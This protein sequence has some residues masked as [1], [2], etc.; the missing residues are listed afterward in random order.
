MVKKGTL[1]NSM[2]KI[3][4]IFLLLI[5]LTGCGNNPSND[6]V[7]SVSE[8][9]PITEKI[10][11]VGEIYGEC[12]ILFD[13]IDYSKLPQERL[14]EIGV[15]FDEEKY[16][17][18]WAFPYKYMLM[19]GNVT[20]NDHKLT[21]DEAKEIIDKY[22]EDGLD[23]IVNEFMKIQPYPDVADGSGM[24]FIHFI[25]DNN[26]DSNNYYKQTGITIMLESRNI[27]YEEYDGEE[28]KFEDL[29]NDYDYINH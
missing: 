19:I 16:T 6:E 17:Y 15:F 7:T 9:V 26:Y 21:L 27:I 3:T 10:K 28:R 23:K 8:T 22:K 29:Y 4:C 2:K 20:E 18:I 1:L 13:N 5:L 12:Y 14:G 11:T 24:S 25:P